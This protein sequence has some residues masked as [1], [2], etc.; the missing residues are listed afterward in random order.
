MNGKITVL[1][2]EDLKKCIA[3]LGRGEA[4][5]LKAANALLDALEVEMVKEQLKD[6]GIADDIK[7][8]G[9]HSRA[10]KVYESLFKVEAM[11]AAWQIQLGAEKA[12]P[13][14]QRW[15]VDIEVT[16]FA[17]EGRDRN[18]VESLQNDLYEIFGIKK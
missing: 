2:K 3:D 17:R 14:L 10:E 5:S 12:S 15:A 18:I 4:P 1:N 16:F 9:K 6:R 7:S 11:K 13:E 8:I